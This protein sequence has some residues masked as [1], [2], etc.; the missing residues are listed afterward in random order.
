MSGLMAE[1][2]YINVARRLLGP[3]GGGQT[4]EAEAALDSPGARLDSLGLASR[5]SK[6]KTPGHLY[7]PL[8]TGHSDLQ[9]ENPPRGGL[10]EFSY[11]L[12]SAKCARNAKLPLSSP[13]SHEAHGSQ[14]ACEKRERRW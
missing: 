6:I 14:Y 11:E 13:P 1:R 8:R 10:S 5:G 3:S 7:L 2:Q 9:N 4:N 12:L